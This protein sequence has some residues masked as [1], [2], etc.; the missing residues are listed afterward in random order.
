M[1]DFGETTFI[2]GAVATTVPTVWVYMVSGAAGAATLGCIA[3][4]VKMLVYPGETA[5]D[6]PKRR[7]LAADR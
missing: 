6:H 2:C 3:A 5:L 4:A 7:I 1:P